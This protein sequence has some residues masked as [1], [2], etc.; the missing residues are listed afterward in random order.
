[1]SRCKWDLWIATRLYKAL[2]LWRRAAE[3]GDAGAYNN[4]GNA[5]YNGKGVEVDK[6]K[7]IHYYELAAMKGC[8]RARNNLG[9]M[10]IMEHRRGNLNRALKHYLIAIEG[11]NSDSLTNIKRLYKSGQAIK[12]EYTKALRLHQEYLDEI[13][14]TRRDEAAAAND[15]YRYY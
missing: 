13:K 11:G 8:M 1:V 9:A 15:K 14:S 5:Y 3:L 10:A 4:I 7:A 2:E 12:D 6:E